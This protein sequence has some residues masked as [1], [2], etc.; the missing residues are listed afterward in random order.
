ME[1]ATILTPTS[2][3][4]NG[5]LLIPSE[6]NIPEG[7]KYEKYEPYINVRGEVLPTPRGTRPLNNLEKRILQK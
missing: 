7:P 3:G 1:S 6:P 2:T 4:L 5:I